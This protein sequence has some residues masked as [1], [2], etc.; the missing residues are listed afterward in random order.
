M[1][2]WYHLSFACITD[3]K[4]GLG[5]QSK[6]SVYLSYPIVATFLLILF[7][8]CGFGFGDFGTIHLTRVNFRINCFMFVD[9]L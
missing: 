2:P 6:L 1:Y 7:Y 3:S 9:L 8:L 4:L 5:Q